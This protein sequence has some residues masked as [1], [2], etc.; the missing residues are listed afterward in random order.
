[1][2]VDLTSGGMPL[3]PNTTRIDVD[4]VNA[5]FVDKG[6]GVVDLNVTG[7]GSSGIDV[8]NGSDPPFSAD[9]ISVDGNNIVATDAGGGV[10]SLVSQLR[11]LS[12]GSP[13]GS[14]YFKT[15]NGYINL[16]AVDAGSGVAALV[17]SLN[18]FNGG[19][20]NL[21]QATV[22]QADGTSIVAS[23][24]GGGIVG[25]AAAAGLSLYGPLA[26]LPAAG[27]AGRLYTPSDAPYQLIDTGSVWLARVNSVLCNSPGSLSG[28]TA[29][30]LGTSTWDVLDQRWLVAA[31]TIASGNQLRG[32]TKAI[33]DASAWTIEAGVDNYIAAVG[34]G[35]ASYPT[36]IY[37][38]AGVCA[39]DSVSGFY[40][41]I[42]RGVY[43]GAS[44]YTQFVAK[45]TDASTRTT[46]N[47]AN[48]GLDARFVRL[49]RAGTTVFGEVS[50]NR[51]DWLTLSQFTVGVLNPTP[52]QYGPCVVNGISGTVNGVFYHYAES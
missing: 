50:S 25:L 41:S 5:S 36:G 46:F 38:T 33:P 44:T 42:S 2:S 51:Y 3:P 48:G 12:A 37:P 6:N 16:S 1:M 28:Y 15:I 52:D 29:F 19:S 35:A 9:T 32:Y 13:V 31:Q 49:R 39:Y 47:E 11:V 8:V 4:G 24:L 7:G 22:L 30:N 45:W 40:C 27:V 10:A 26:S 21:G 17:A 20:T 18:V 23:N 34:S 14:G 43:N